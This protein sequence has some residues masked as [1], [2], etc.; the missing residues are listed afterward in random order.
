[1]TSQPHRVTVIPGD[2][3]G[4]EVIRAAVR[5]IDAAGVKIEWEEA[6]AGAEVFMKGETSGVPQATRDSIARTKVVLKG[7]L[8]TPVGF[9]EKSA[10]ERPLAER[11]GS[12]GIALAGM[13][14]GA[15][16]MPGPKE[17]PLEVQS[18]RDGVVTL[19]GLY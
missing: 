11:S 19:F 3:V 6:E 18:F 13:P 7:P 2:G 4:P 14:P 10:I 12:D 16:G 17:A 9:G 15:P 5:I 1:M 8:E